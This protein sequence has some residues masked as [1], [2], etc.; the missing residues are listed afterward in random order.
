MSWLNPL[1]YSTKKMIKNLQKIFDKDL[2]WSGTILK[3]VFLYVENSWQWSNRVGYHEQISLTLDLKVQKFANIV[4]RF[5]NYLILKILKKCRLEKKVKTTNLQLKVPE[6]IGYCISTWK[7]FLS[8]YNE[9]NFI[10]KIK[11][12]SKQITNFAEN[13]LES[14]VDCW[15]SS[16]LNWLPE[17]LDLHIETEEEDN[18]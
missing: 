2:Y 17:G 9:I 4:E 14:L 16:W 12:F 8:D 6:K 15:V 7:Y 11:V 10:I 5:A 13:E 18:M 1:W 3:T